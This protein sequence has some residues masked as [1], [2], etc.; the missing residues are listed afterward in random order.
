MNTILKHCTIILNCELK[1]LKKNINDVESV[2]DKE[3]IL[4]FNTYYKFVDNE[5]CIEFIDNSLFLIKNEL[6]KM[7][8]EDL[9]TILIIIL[10]AFLDKNINEKSRELYVNSDDILNITITHYK[11]YLMLSK[12]YIP[13]KQ[14]NVTC[15][16]IIDL[17]SKKKQIF[18]KIINIKSKNYY[19]TVKFYYINNLNYKK[20][21]TE[22]MLFSYKDYELIEFNDDHYITTGHFSKTFELYKKNFSSNKSF[23]LKKIGYIINKINVK[24]YVD[25]EYQKTLKILLNIDKTAILENIRI[26]T[27]IINKLFNN[28]NWTSLTKEKISELQSKNSKLA[29]LLMYD[30]FTEID[31]KD[32]FIYFPIFLDFRGRKYYYSKIG[33]TS[34]RLMRLCYHYG[35]YNN[36]EFKEKNNIYSYKYYHIIDLF[37]LNHNVLNNKRY[38]ESY[39]WCLIGIGKFF[40]NKQEYPVK[41][42]KFLELGIK[43]YDNMDSLEIDEKLE[44]LHYK[45]IIRDADMK[46]PIKRAII[47]DATASIN[48]IFMKKLG[49]LDHVSMDYVNL[50][51]D[52]EW[53]DT[54]SVCKTLFY[55]YIKDDEFFKSNWNKE[56]FDNVLPRFLIKNP[57]MIIPYSAGNI[58]CW[59]NY[60]KLA[61]ERRSDIKP[62]KKL[63]KLMNF[64]FNF[65]RNDMQELYLY[66]KT[67]TTLIHKISEEFESLRKYILESDTG[68]ADISYYKMKRSSI[69]KKY[70]LNGEKKRITK[71]ILTPSE[72]LDKEA[73][74]IAAGA[75]TVHFFDADEIRSI[76]YELGYSVITIHDSYL[77]DYNNCSKLIKIKIKHYQKE[78]D[79]ITPKYKINNIFILL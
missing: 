9:V 72:A 24:L 7:K 62:D 75:N 73:F 68:M 32:N 4:V 60:V 35:W 6:I 22:S 8:E 48:Q 39:F 66:N 14:I 70:I 57:I 1:L 38:Y 11:N 36:D 34:S 23:K 13:D 42:E 21:L 77:I 5:Y 63:K 40:V 49:P 15:L 54:Y 55:D 44:I 71:L 74:D 26:N 30:S 76:E 56:S 47:K 31:F 58:L 41:P 67:S 37:C 52:W 28:N 53:Y 2:I 16:Y 45:R 29:D 25:S 46:R 65:I 61:S 20:D 51:E 69:D 50:G 3:K 10:K 33:P 18:E 19:K 43:N 27:E 78:I 79:K 17:L 64:F 12:K 59:K